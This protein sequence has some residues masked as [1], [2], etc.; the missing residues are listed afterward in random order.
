LAGHL[1][2]CGPRSSGL[3]PVGA[4]ATCRDAQ[5]RT[6]RGRSVRPKA[7]CV[8]YGRCPR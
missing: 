3:P 7:K 5:Q 8:H 4:G 2:V 6:D 1:P